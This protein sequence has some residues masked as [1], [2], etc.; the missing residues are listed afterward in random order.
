[1]CAYLLFIYYLFIIIY[2]VLNFSEGRISV[3][4][5]YLMFNLSSLN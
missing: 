4:C 1:M 5:K 3:Q 2:Y